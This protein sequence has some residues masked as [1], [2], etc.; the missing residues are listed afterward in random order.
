[1]GGNWELAD[2]EL[3]PPRAGEALVRVAYA[4]LCYSDEHIRKGTEQLPGGILSMYSKRILGSL[5]G[6]CNPRNDIPKFLGLYRTGHLELDELIT[7]R[8]DLAE[9]GQGN[10]D[11]DE[12][13]LIRGLVAINPQ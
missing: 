12:G 9:V 10:Q 5:Y 13:K 6:G 8:Y 1:M 11:L 4:G 3:D 2:L 7:H